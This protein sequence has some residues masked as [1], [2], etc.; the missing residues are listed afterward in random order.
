MKY[1]RKS[2]YKYRIRM[3][4]KYFYKPQMFTK[5][6]DLFRSICKQGLAAGAAER[7]SHRD[8][9]AQQRSLRQW[10]LWKDWK[11]RLFRAPIWHDA[12]WPQSTSTAGAGDDT[13]TKHR[14]GH[15]A[16]PENHGSIVL[17]WP[18]SS[19]ALPPASKKERKGWFIN[20]KTLPAY[21]LVQYKGQKNCFLGIKP[22][23]SPQQHSV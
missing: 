8:G 16:E 1:I 5:S 7:K 6:A 4:T 13:R 22:S 19:A 10:R 11:S 9:T 17:W 23:F 20:Y 21:T 18:S 15:H 3:R 12:V 14:G 2:R